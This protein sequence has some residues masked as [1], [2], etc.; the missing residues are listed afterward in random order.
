[1]TGNGLYIHYIPPIKMVM[2]GGWFILYT[3]VPQFSETSACG[4]HRFRFLIRRWNPQGFWIGWNSLELASMFDLLV[5]KNNKQTRIPFSTSYFQWRPGFFIFD[6][7]I[8][9]ESLLWCWIE[10]F[11]SLNKQ[12]VREIAELEFRKTFKR[13]RG[14]QRK[15]KMIW[16]AN[17]WGFRGSAPFISILF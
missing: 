13:C 17:S 2:T 9:I 3:W 1:M 15:A 6:A 7:Q 14:S 10:V 8:L 4:W 5:W 12:E 11:K 16:K